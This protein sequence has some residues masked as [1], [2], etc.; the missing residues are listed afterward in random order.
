M[1]KKQIKIEKDIPTDL[2]DHTFFGLP[3]DDEQIK[4]RDAIWS[5]DY[6]IVLCEAK[7]GTGKTTIAVATAML[8]YEYGLIDSIV[9]MSAAGVHEYKQGLLPGTIE[10]KSSLLFIP[11]KQALL[12]IGYEPEHIVCSDLNVVA[13]KNGYACILAQTDSY[14]RGINIGDSER[15]VL[16]IVDETQNFDR[17]ALRSVL[18]RVGENSKTV[19]IGSDSQCDLKYPQDSAFS[20]A[21]N[22]YNLAPRCKICNLSKCY[23][24]WVAELADEI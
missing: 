15:R 22:L 9:Y 6:D 1:S 14:V 7:S 4:F 20:R 2:S 19:V 11:L 8:M 10:E 5:N 21:I 16:L 12:K 24:S 18:S 3:L 17:K 23:R 13:Q